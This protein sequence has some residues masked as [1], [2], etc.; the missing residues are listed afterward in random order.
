MARLAR[1]AATAKSGRF[2]IAL[3]SGEP[4]IG[5]SAL[6]DTA[7]RRLAG[8][9]WTVAW[10]NC[11]EREGSPAGQ[12][13][14]EILQG[15]VDRFPPRQ[16]A[17]ELAPLLDDHATLRAAGDVPAARY[18]LR[19]AVGRYLAAVTRG[20]PL[21]VVLD[22]LHHA[23]G[24]VLALLAHLAGD[25]PG[26]QVLLVATYRPTEVDEQLADTLA[27]LARHGPEHLTLTG[28]DAGAV[29]QLIDELCTRPLAD[30]T[31]DAIARRTEGN[32]FFVREIA[33]LLETDGEHAAI[34]EVPASVRHIVRRRVARLPGSAQSV[35][36]FA[37]VIGREFTLDVL[38]AVTRLGEDAL[39]E[40]LD[41][42]LRAGIL[43]EPHTAVRSLRFAH[44][45]VR[46]TLYHD[47]SRLRRTGLHAR[48]GAALEQVRPGDAVALAHHF[49]AAQAPDAAARAAR[50]PAARGRAGGAALR[51]PRGGRAVAAGRAVLRA[52]A[53]WHGARPARAGDR[54]DPHAVGRGG[55]A[56]GE[57][58]A[59][60]HARRGRRDR[61]RG[62][63]RAGDRGLRRARPVPASPDGRR[64]RS[65]S[66]T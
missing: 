20:G 35:L 1:A 48:V 15:L 52:R 24:E 21:L 60:R 54:H 47:I 62:A 9:G 43:D 59:R 61:G 44:A 25:L 17:T 23:D 57:R 42:A 8:Q 56:G 46:D 50:V 16:H 51:P 34:G 3:L 12:P 58:A 53:G 41:A 18:R 22:D 33:R 32:P 13:W 11:P 55:A 38:S 31:V 49:D 5:K 64:C 27:T 63:D 36:Q 4:G 10:G 6:A 30:Q 40:I 28:L 65:S 29:A 19:T 26:E 2:T 66:S 7:A 45:L 14:T 37:A 39:I